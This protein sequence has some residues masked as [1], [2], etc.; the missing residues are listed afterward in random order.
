[1]IPYISAQHSMWSCGGF[2]TTKTDYT[3]IKADQYGNPIELN[4]QGVTTIMIWSHKGQRPIA[5][6]QNATYD[7]VVAALGKT[8]EEYSVL[9][10]SSLSLEN[11]RTALPK[12][13]VYTYMYDNR[14]NLI[15]K[16]DPNGL[17]HLYTYDSLNRLTAERRQYGNK[18]ELLNS[19][20]YNYKTK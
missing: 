2:E 17:V 9:N 15:S 5:S 20:Q 16:T 3:V 12:A 10:T 18:T 8:P 4:E 19:Y 7:E 13:L 1:M 6:I 14:L 11:L